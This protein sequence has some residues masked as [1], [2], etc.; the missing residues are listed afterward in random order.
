MF[1]ASPD[2]LVGE[3][4]I[5]QIKCPTPKTHL[6][7]LTAG[8]IPVEHV[9]QMLAELACTGREWCDFVSYHPLLPLFVRRYER[10]EKLIATLEAEVEHFNRELEG[11]LKCLPPQPAVKLLEEPNEDEVQF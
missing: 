3:D 9:P 10:D 5:I 7:W 4:G 6:K 1:G 8:T 11:V 2:R